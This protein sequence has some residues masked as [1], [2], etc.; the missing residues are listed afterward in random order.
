MGV[1]YGLFIA[2]TRLKTE[3]KI[4]REKFE[5]LEKRYKKLFGQYRGSE[6]TNG[7][8][9]ERIKKLQTKLEK[10]QRVLAELSDK[11]AQRENELRSLEFEL[12]EERS[13]KRGRWKK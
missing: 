9:Y 8:L 10:A 11:L 13:K 6:E 2:P 4:P 1:I 7:S 5:S 3:R 12:H